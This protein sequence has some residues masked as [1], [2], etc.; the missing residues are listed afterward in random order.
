MNLFWPRVQ[1][2]KNL[3]KIGPVAYALDLGQHNNINIDV[4]LGSGNLK[5]DISAENTTSYFNSGEK[6]KSAVCPLLILL[7]HSF[8]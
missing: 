5:T 3:N 1:I 8:K 4:F 7:V 6:A 2:Y